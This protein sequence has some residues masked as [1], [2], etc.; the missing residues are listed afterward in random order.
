MLKKR[1]VDKRFVDYIFLTGLP[2]DFRINPKEPELTDQLSSSEDKS[3]K[4]FI[5]EEHS[6]DK[7]NDDFTEEEVRVPK[8]RENDT[9]T[10]KENGTVTRNIDR[11]S[12]NFT[13][14]IDMT[15]TSIFSNF[16]S[17]TT[18][19]ST[20]NISAPD[21]SDS[22]TSSKLFERYSKDLVT[23]DDESK[24]LYDSL[25]ESIRMNIS[26]FDQERDEFLKSLGKGVKIPSI[27][28][29]KSFNKSSND[30]GDDGS[31]C[32]SVI[33]VKNKLLKDID[34]VD[35]I[36]SFS[37]NDIQEKSSDTRH[38]YQ[39]VV[40]QQ[41]SSKQN[42]VES[43]TI[44][45]P[46]KQKISPKLLSRY[47][48]YDYPKEGAFPA[49]VPM[50]C[51]PNDIMIR[52]S[53]TCPTTTFHGFVMTQEDG[54]QRYGVCLTTFEPIPD[55]LFEELYEQQ[56]TWREAKMSL[57]E[58]EYAEHLN[59]KI[60]IERKRMET[61]R[62]KILLQGLKSSKELEEIEKEKIDATEKLALY[63]E[64]LQ[65]IKLGVL[66]KSNL[67]IP[68]CIGIVSHLPWHDVLKDWLCA[69]VMPMIEG[70]KE[71][72][73][74]IKSLIPLE[75]Y[76]VNL[77]HEIPLPPP[78]KLQV[79]L[80]V[81]DLTFFCTRPALNQMPIMKD[82]S[83]YPL[84]RSL[85]IKNI[86]TLF[87]VALAERKILIISSYLDMLYLVAH[88]ITYLIYPFYW[89]GVF[90]PVLPARLMACL[91]APVPYI[92]GIERQYKGI[93]LLPEDACILDVDK[94]TI[95]M[96][97]LP[98]QVPSRQRKK[99]IKSL[100][101]Y[102][103]LHT[104]YNVPLGVP[105]FVQQAYPNGRFMPVSNRS[106]MYDKTGD[107]IGSVVGMPSRAIPLALSMSSSFD[108]ENGLMKP[109]SNGEIDQALH[110]API[111]NPDNYSSNNSSSSS[112][113]DLFDY[114]C[115]NSDLGLSNTSIKTQSNI[116][117]SSVSMSNINLGNNN[118]STRTIQRRFSNFVSPSFSN[119][120]ENIRNLD[121]F[122]R[123]TKQR[124]SSITGGAR[125]SIM[126]FKNK[127]LTRK[128]FSI[129]ILNG[130]DSQSN[131]VSNNSSVISPPTSPYS[132]NYSD[133]LFDDTSSKIYSNNKLP[134]GISPEKNYIPKEGHLM[135]LLPPDIEEFGHKSG[136]NTWMMEGLACSVCRDSLGINTVYKCEGCSI[137][138]HDECLNDIVNPCIPA[139]FDESKIS[140]AFLRLFASL[141][142]DYRYFLANKINR[143]GTDS[144][145]CETVDNGFG[146]VEDANELF[147]KD[148]FLKTVDKDAKAFLSNL[149]DSQSFSQFITERAIRESED[150]DIRYFDEII[151]AKLNR[152]KLKLSKESTSF[153]DDTS[154]DIS[155]T[156][157]A[158][159]PNEEGLDELGFEGY[160]CL[161]DCFDPELICTPRPVRDG[162][163]N[164]FG[165]G[166]R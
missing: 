22:N 72:N 19:T 41:P 156:V 9:M 37:S 100:E 35:S 21:N 116:V 12:L 105:A 97:E 79:A 94:D 160:I 11:L 110:F 33:S 66:D 24:K 76:I 17:E 138:I 158:M 73:E 149:L 142:K 95:L 51:F 121:K 16:I 43:D 44:V 8:A 155:Q 18:T 92:M 85:S 122:G 98:I 5:K 23:N 120:T 117:R 48:K 134:P 45:H 86:I 135:T 165:K 152:S 129:N 119:K 125:N 81:N 7:D 56:K 140:E 58:I 96:A 4:V 57:S 83:L 153:L 148:L 30:D 132:T 123:K 64:L 36:L 75:R 74:T 31:E 70:L 68:K 141:L 67:W 107:R 111:Y 6:N 55:D 29:G 63:N 3:E 27:V 52:E 15:D 77:V 62:A 128:S 163:A 151:K 133:S 146:A 150:Y 20:S 26:K 115:N 54:S 91:Q 139:S 159:K 145:A 82:F 25:L 143:S 84:F 103:P 69:V 32:E 127:A 50:F 89:Q 49:Y 162:W 147:K 46:L 108:P 137:M 38:S 65:P 106:K 42:V 118:N 131:S 47:P 124:F 88:S 61:A 90:I 80:S 40:P 154:F 99:L 87:E 10:T 34:E 71:K 126:T 157:R 101:K 164:G 39:N 113:S 130:G 59:E 102:S 136:I 93:D 78:G 161:P 53:D 109:N 60:R 1:T 166:W 13:P 114:Y 104:H 14:F 144:R 28:T 2:T 112:V